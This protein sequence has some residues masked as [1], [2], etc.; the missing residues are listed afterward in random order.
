MWIMRY[1]NDTYIEIC[2]WKFRNWEQKQICREDTITHF[3]GIGAKSFVKKFRL[4]LNSE[5]S[6]FHKLN[7]VHRSTIS[8]I[9]ATL[10]LIVATHWTTQVRLS[11]GSMARTTTTLSCASFLAFSACSRYPWLLRSGPVKGIFT[12]ESSRNFTRKNLEK[13]ECISST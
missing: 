5:I 2:K 1:R 9:V 3:C 13:T 7:L 6:P 8:Y 12:E 11:S 10:M 4:V